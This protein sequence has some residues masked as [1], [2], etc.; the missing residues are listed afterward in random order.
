LPT[1]KSSG[2]KVAAADHEL[3]TPD[4]D[5]PEGVFL[6]G[7][8]IPEGRTHLFTLEG[9][10]YTA[11]SKLPPNITFKMLRKA[12]TDGTEAAMLELAEAVIGSDVVDI[13]A[14]HDELTE[15]EFEAIMRV[16]EKHSMSVFDQSAGKSRKERRRSS[17]S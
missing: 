4:Q 8:E 11:P 10:M 12:R 9:R 5:L 2:I 13:L 7:T 16:V 1:P 15:Q 3:D 17:G 6:E 14:D